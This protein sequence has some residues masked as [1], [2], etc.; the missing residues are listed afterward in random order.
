MHIIENIIILLV[1]LSRNCHITLPH[2]P[3]HF[4]LISGSVQF[5]LFGFV[6]L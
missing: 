4:G 6:K 5:G 3:G 1:N 2:R